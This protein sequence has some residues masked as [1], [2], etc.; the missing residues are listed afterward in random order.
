MEGVLFPNSEVPIPSIFFFNFDF[1]LPDNFWKP[2][3]PLSNNSFYYYFRLMLDSCYQ[4]RQ[5][6]VKVII[7]TAIVVILDLV[8]QLHIP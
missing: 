5:R 3:F 7:P 8:K 6:G 1:F 4:I 2:P